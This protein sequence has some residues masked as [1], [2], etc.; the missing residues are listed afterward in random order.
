[1]GWDL[2]EVNRERLRV[3]GPTH[4]EAGEHLRTSTFPWKARVEGVQ[5]G[6]REGWDGGL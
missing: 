5:G 4:A 6:D 2:A 3:E 1:M